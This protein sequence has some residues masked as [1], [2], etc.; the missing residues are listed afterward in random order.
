[1]EIQQ[2]QSI[3][4]NRAYTKS[5]KGPL[6]TPW[7]MGLNGMIAGL[8]PYEAFKTSVEK[9]GGMTIV[10]NRQKSDDG[11]IVTKLTQE[12]PGQLISIERHTG[13]LKSAPGLLL[14]ATG[15]RIEDEL[16]GSPVITQREVT[17]LVV[18]AF[19]V[20]KIADAHDATLSRIYGDN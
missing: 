17:S 12:Y 9:H 10:E 18:G 2:S 13:N 16:Y 7:W 3:R 5:K 11:I 14:D 8:T 1:M 19:S 6:Y 15:V 20:A 4:H